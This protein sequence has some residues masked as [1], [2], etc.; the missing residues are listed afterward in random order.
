VGGGVGASRST[1]PQ[2]GPPD[3]ARVIPLR[4]SPET[5]KSQRRKNSSD[6]EQNEVRWLSLDPFLKIE[7]LRVDARPCDND[8]AQIGNVGACG[9]VGT[10]TQ[11]Q[12][13]SPNRSA[14]ACAFDDRS[15]AV[16]GLSPSLIVVLRV[17]HIEMECISHEREMSLRMLASFG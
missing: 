3:L 13:I 6:Q 15:R 4:D 16:V 10:P 14:A 17:I 2:A 12:K 5:T 8:L 7:G 11:L 1:I 9:L